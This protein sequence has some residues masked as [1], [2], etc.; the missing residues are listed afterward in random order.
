MFWGGQFITI[1]CRRKDISLQYCMTEHCLF[2]YFIFFRNH[3]IL[4]L[5]GY[6][7]MYTTNIP[8]LV[9]QSSHLDKFIIPTSNE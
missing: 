5:G 8:E 2:I 1:F 7:I 9:G 4:F 3:Q 6:T